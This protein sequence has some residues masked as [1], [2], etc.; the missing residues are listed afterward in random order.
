MSR[1]R[2]LDG[3]SSPG[4]AARLLECPAE[5]VV[6]EDRAG[7]GRARLQNTPTTAT[8]LCLVLSSQCRDPRLLHSGAR[9]F[10]SARLIN[11]NSGVPH[12][13]TSVR[14]TGESTP[15]CY[16]TR[17][18]GTWTFTGGTTTSFLLP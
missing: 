17:S 8:V 6:W 9:M 11:Q 2:P 18:R 10:I 4:C 13:A 3:S 12:L 15:T 1:K 5:V 7:C 14:G 16:R